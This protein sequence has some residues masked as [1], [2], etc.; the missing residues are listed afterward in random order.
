MLAA[1]VVGAILLSTSRI[2]EDREEEKAKRDAL[3]QFLTSD[4]DAPKTD[5]G[6]P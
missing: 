6:P 5:N 1:L 2:L 3:R 4:S